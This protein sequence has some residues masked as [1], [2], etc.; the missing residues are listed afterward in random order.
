EMRVGRRCRGQWRERRICVV[1]GV[2]EP[3][4]EREAAAIAS[5]RGNG[6]PATRHD[7]SVGPAAGPLLEGHAPARTLPHGVDGAATEAEAAPIGCGGGKGE[8]ASRHD[9][10]V[11]PDAGAILA[12]HEPALPL[13][14]DVDDAGTEAEARARAASD[15]KQSVAHI[16][17]TVAPREQLPGFRLEIERHAQLGLEE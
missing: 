10:S 5:G 17:G 7:D 6:E 1:Y 8:P 11:G 3:A 13:W 14:H 2:T 16:T 12:G 4:R 15:G 9:D